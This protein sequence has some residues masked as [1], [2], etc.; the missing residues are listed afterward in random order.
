MNGKALIKYSELCKN[1]SAM[2]AWE[3]EWR[4]LVA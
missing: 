4:T 2:K 1:K 3:K